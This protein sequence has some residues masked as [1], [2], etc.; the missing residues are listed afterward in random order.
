MTW[1]SRQKPLTGR[2]EEEPG[3]GGEGGESPE[4]A[5]RDGRTVRGKFVEWCGE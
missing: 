3:V 5:Q 1:R 4:R 2:L